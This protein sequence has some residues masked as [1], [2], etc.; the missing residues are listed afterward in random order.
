VNPLVQ[1][2]DNKQRDQRCYQDND[3][4]SSGRRYD[5]PIV[6]VFASGSS[7]SYYRIQGKINAVDEQK[8]DDKKIVNMNEN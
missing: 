2:P 3:N 7:G 8:H 6:V 4:D 1:S 5:E